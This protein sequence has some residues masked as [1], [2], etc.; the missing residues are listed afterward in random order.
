MGPYSVNRGFDASAKCYDLVQPARTVRADLCT[1]LYSRKT[2]V[3]R[4]ILE[5]D[6]V[7]NNCFCCTAGRGIKLHLVTAQGLFFLFLDYRS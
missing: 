5:S 3:F 1:F 7:Q 2:N 6:C 4:D